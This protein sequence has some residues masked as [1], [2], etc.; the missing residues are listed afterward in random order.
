MR[1]IQ[2]PAPRALGAGQKMVAYYAKLNRWG[3]V[4]FYNNSGFNGL[5]PESIGK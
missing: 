5:S 2:I 3:I 4:L 1:K